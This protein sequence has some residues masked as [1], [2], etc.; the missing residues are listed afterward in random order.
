MTEFFLT[1]VLPDEMYDRRVTF[2]LLQVC[3][4][5]DNVRLEYI[6]RERHYSST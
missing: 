4:A 5:P 2:I 3:D 6:E 1:L